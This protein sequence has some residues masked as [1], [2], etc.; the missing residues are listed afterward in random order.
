MVEALESETPDDSDIFV[1]LHAL[2]K[3]Q[4]AAGRSRAAARARANEEERKVELATGFVNLEEMLHKA[5]KA[6]RNEL[7]ALKSPDTDKVVARVR[8]DVEALAAMQRVQ[9]QR[10]ATRLALQVH[11]LQLAKE[12]LAKVKGDALQVG[13]A[14]LGLA[15]QK[16]PQLD[17]EPK[18]AAYDFKGWSFAQPAHP[19]AKG[20]AELL[21]ELGRTPSADQV[22]TV[23][24]YKEDGTTLYTAPPIPPRP[25]DK[26]QRRV[27]P[28]MVESTDYTSA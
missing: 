10:Q 2:V 14:L 16:S 26:S 20:R 13:V 11:R 25:R 3:D 22:A 28:G 5:K 6:T 7:I 12:T 9:E 4:P 24:L 21:A 23:T 8:V 19:G 15:E 17:F 18:Q 27:R 1:V